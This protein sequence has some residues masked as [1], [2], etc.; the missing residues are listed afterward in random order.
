M[1]LR[2]YPNSNDYLRFRLDWFSDGFLR[3]HSFRNSYSRVGDTS[4]VFESSLYSSSIDERFVTDEISLRRASISNSD[5]IA[6]PDEELT[7]SYRPVAA[8]SI[9]PYSQ[10]LAVRDSQRIDWDGQY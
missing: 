7:D 5:R 1:T 6:C 4:I 9:V 2:G 8:V 3:D 10:Q